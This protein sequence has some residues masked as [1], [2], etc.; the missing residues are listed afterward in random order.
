MFPAGG[1]NTQ[2]YFITRIED[3][4]GI[5]LMNMAP[6]QKELISAQTAFKMVRMMRGVVDIGTGKRMRFRYGI[7]AEMAGKTGTTN[8][9][10]DGWFIGY[11]PQILGGAWV[12]CDDRFLHFQ[13]EALGQGAAAAL[14]IFAYFMKK[15]YADKS[16]D[17]REDVKFDIPKD[18]DDCDY[19]YGV[20]EERGRSLRSGSSGWSPSDDGDINEADVNSTDDGGYFVPDVPAEETEAPAEGE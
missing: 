14:P 13:S 10:A 17:I 6:K 1:M 8:E 12:G 7:Q 2:P 20:S 11:T 3:K 5:V 16:L 18:F 19:D 9:Q 4:N 15:C